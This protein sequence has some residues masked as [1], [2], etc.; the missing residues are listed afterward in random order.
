MILK[1]CYLKKMKLVRT[2]KTS[3]VARECKADCLYAV[4]KRAVFVPLSGEREVARSNLR[5]LTMRLSSSTWLRMMLEVVQ[6]WV[7][8][9]PCTLSVHFPSMS[10]LIPSDFESR[11]P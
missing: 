3:S 4:F 5:P 10:P 9:R 11:T 1:G 7:T 6:D 8:V 2:L